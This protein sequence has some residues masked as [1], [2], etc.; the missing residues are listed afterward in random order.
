MSLHLSSLVIHEKFGNN[1]SEFSTAPNQ[2]YF[3]RVLGL[4]IGFFI[5]NV[6]LYH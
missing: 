2:F 3:I 1:R 6:N 4:K 5:K